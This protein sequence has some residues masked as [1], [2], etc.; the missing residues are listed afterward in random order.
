MK[1]LIIAA[2]FIVT[3]GALAQNSAIE[4]LRQ[5]LKTGKVAL[6][7]ANLPLTEK[8]AETFWPLYRE[9]DNELSKL[10]DRRVAVLKRYAQTYN[11]VTEMAAGEM[12]KESFSISRDRTALLEQTYDKVA[13]ALNVKLAARFVQIENQMLTLID[14]KLMDEVPLIKAPAAPAGGE[15]K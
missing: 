13:K 1:S 14:A 10:G 2:M 7:T 3:T 12:I 9:Y 4:L 11:N 15:K 8:E 5:D 6:I